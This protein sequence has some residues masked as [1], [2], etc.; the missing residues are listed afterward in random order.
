MGRG[1]FPPI[2][3]HARNYRVLSTTDSPSPPPPTRA[4][5]FDGT[6]R[7]HEGRFSAS[8][9]RPGS[10]SR[11]APPRR[12]AGP[13]E[14]ATR[15]HGSGPGEAVPGRRDEPTTPSAVH[16]PAAPGEGPSGPS[17]GLA[18]RRTTTRGSDAQR[19]LHAPTARRPIRRRAAPRG[20]GQL[21]HGRHRRRPRETFG[22]A[23]GRARGTAL[24]TVR[25]GE[26]GSTRGHGP[27]G[28]EDHRSDQRSSHRPKPRT[29]TCSRPCVRHRVHH[30]TGGGDRAGNRGRWSACPTDSTPASM[31][32]VVCYPPEVRKA[33]WRYR[34]ARL[35]AYVWP[36]GRCA[37][38]A[39]RSSRGA[40]GD[41]PPVPLGAGLPEPLGAHPAWR[42]T[43]EPR[44]G[45]RVRSRARRSGALMN[46]AVNRRVGRT[47]AISARWPTGPST[48]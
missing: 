27:N 1:D 33:V 14:G 47:S 45:P 24:R 40:P 2:H 20:V 28:R 21:A 15:T 3:S 37:A 4:S 31:L 16:P 48:A 19:R 29:G 23:R 13:V 10:G 42:R 39:A 12:P 9:S 35:S 25:G 18:R 22:A 43:D 11:A 46:R 36:T 34:S 30:R 17:S 32:C 38:R 44:W 6:E 41:R 8:S 5:D 7:T 26:L